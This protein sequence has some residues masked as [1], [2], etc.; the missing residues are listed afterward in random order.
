M[1]KP[2]D[3]GLLDFASVDNILRLAL[4]PPEA[5]VVPEQ[6]QFD[7]TQPYEAPAQLN[8]GN[9]GELKP[10]MMEGLRNPQAVQ[11]DYKSLANQFGAQ[12]TSLTR[13]PEHNRK[14]GGVANSQHI[15]GTG[16][17]FV[18]PGS[19][20]A[21]FIA[22]VRARGYEPIDEGDHIHVQLPRATRNSALGINVFTDAIRYVETR[23]QKMPY[24]AKNK[25]TSASGAYQYTNGT[26]GNYGGYPEARL[27]PKHVQDAKF[28]EDSMR[29]LRKFNGDP[30]KMIANHMLPAQ[31][32]KPWLWEQPSTLVVTRNG[33]KQIVQIP[34][35]ADYVR[36]AL[37]QTPWAGQFNQYMQ[38]YRQ[39]Q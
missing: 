2:Q 11:A 21:A 4:S 30:F 10:Q 6:P 32:N 35:V 3:G 34:P 1:E 37:T 20:K 15:S 28:A 38:A 27:A 23:G 8:F 31:A 33:K 5:Q 24:Q 26:W 25:T 18:V 9:M 13:T 22:A 29:S 7:A 39:Q 14:V 17:D 12:I 19:Q 36:K 16:G